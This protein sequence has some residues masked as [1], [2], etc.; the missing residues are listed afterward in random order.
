MEIMD[1]FFHG[2]SNSQLII[3]VI[4]AIL[5]GINK[6][7]MPGLGLLPVVML[8]LWFDSRISPGLQLVMLAVTDLFAVIYYRHKANWP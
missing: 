2:M 7:G 1:F 6:T 4:S 5:I 8:A 3:L